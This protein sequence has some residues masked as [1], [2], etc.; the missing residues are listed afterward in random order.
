MCFDFELEVAEH[1]LHV[2]RKGLSHVTYLAQRLQVLTG[3]LTYLAQRLQVLTRQLRPRIPILSETPCLA[4]A[5]SHPTGSCS[6]AYQGR[7]GL[8]IKTIKL[9]YIDTAFLVCHLHTKSYGFRL[10]TEL[11]V[12][13]HQGLSDIPCLQAAAAVLYIGH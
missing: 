2:A 1:L 11:E 4:P 10:I 13:E 8:T 3:Q 12:A 6:H 7:Q 5:S 9:I